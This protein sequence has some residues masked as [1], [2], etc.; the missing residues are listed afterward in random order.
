MA[1]KDLYVN[2]NKKQVA[3]ALLLVV[4]ASVLALSLLYWRELNDFIFKG[5]AETRLAKIARETEECIAGFDFKNIPADDEARNKEDLAKY[6][7]CRAQILKS[8]KECDILSGMNKNVCY[9][10]VNDFVTATAMYNFL[11]E[12]SKKEISCGQD[13]L[14]MCNS[15]VDNLFSFDYLV[16]PDA[17]SKVCADACKAFKQRDAAGLASVIHNT[18]TRQT[19]LNTAS[20]PPEKTR[21]DIAAIFDLNEEK[22]DLS[23]GGG[24]DCKNEI[25]YLK[26]KQLNDKTVCDKMIN[27]GGVMK[28]V[29]KEICQAQFE[30][31]KV[32]YCDR[33]LAGYKYNYCSEKIIAENQ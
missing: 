21:R 8:R 22:C 7:V 23:V 15:L 2:I 24:I 10:D 12:E 6:A 18:F 19:P 5:K 13:A 9:S 33:Y 28:D 25:L 14:K 11:F 20:E 26:A 1:L 30:G 3:L 16:S 29:F 31:N 27:V 17:K 4:L 32:E